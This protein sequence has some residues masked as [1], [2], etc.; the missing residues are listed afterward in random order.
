M[1]RL[2]QSQSDAARWAA[3]IEHAVSVLSNY[4]KS[5]IAITLTTKQ[6]A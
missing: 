4:G 5:V 2:M 3:L 6:V 1:F